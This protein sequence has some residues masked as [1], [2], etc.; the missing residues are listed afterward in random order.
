MLRRA[1]E[2]EHQANVEP[3]LDEVIER[4]ISENVG[5]RKESRLACAITWASSTRS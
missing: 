4:D 5:A 3:E 1:L 2:A